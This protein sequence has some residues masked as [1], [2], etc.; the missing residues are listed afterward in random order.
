MR[1]AALA[2]VALGSALFLSRTAQ[3]D[4]EIAC[5]AVLCLVGEAAGQGGGGSCETCSG[6]MGA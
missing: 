6:Y 2:V 1:W 3:A 5:G 4:N